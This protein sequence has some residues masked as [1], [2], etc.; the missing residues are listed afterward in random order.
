MGPGRNTGVQRKASGCCQ[1]AR[2]VIFRRPWGQSLQSEGLLATMGSECDAVGY[3]VACQVVQ[4]RG[5]LVVPIKPGSA[6]G[7]I[8]GPEEESG[9]VVSWPMVLRLCESSSSCQRAAPHAVRVPS[10]TNN[11]N[12]VRSC[13]QSLLLMILL[14]GSLLNSAIFA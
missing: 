2:L 3:G 10:N 8:T 11:T 9:L 4:C 1:I 14:H 5:L 6:E 7:E 13:M 12:E